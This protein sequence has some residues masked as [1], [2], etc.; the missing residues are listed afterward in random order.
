MLTSLG[1]EH[2]KQRRALQ[3]LFSPKAVEA[4]ADVITDAASDWSSARMNDER[5]DIADQ[6]RT[7]A[8]RIMMHAL[9]GSDIQDEDGA[10]W[11]AIRVRRVYHEHV[12]GAVLPLPQF[13]PSRILFQ[14]S[15]A[16]RHIDAALNRVIS[17]RRA[18]TRHSND[19]ISRWTRTSYEDGRSMGDAQIRAEALNFIDTGYETISAAL[20]WTWYLLAEHAQVEGRVTEE[21]RDVLA[22]NC[23]TPEMSRSCRIPQRFSGNLF[24]CT[25][26]PGALRG[27]HSLRMCC[28]LMSR[29]RQE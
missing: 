11:H 29:S 17:L 1:G 10:L 13:Q 9:F 12:V 7:L 8:Q 21:L 28:P 2:R 25:P 23:R 18:S 26:Q 4:F 27:R 16:I 6:M 14:Y 15:K 20:A 22:G 3:P 19:M 24:V 5:L